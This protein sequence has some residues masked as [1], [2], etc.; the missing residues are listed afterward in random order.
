ML[1]KLVEDDWG[2]FDAGWNISQLEDAIRDMQPARIVVDDAH[3]GGDRLIGLRQLRTQMN[4]DFTIVA[5]TWPGSV[6][7]V[8]ETL[9][10]AAQFEIV[11]LERDQT[12]SVIEELGI[13]GQVGLQAELVNQAHGRVGLA[14]GRRTGGCNW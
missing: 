5:V 1:Q 11:E 6:D 7:E 9:P 3:L 12:L 2:L 8:S 14:G 13:K 4:A 10:G